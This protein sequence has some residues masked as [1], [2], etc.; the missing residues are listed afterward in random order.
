MVTQ[1][2]D[3]QIRLNDVVSALSMAMDMQMGFTVE[4]AIRCAYMSLRMADKLNLS[5]Q[6]RLDIYYGSLLKDV[7]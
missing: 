4:H 7:G 1:P 5:E 6:D 3:T 2:Q